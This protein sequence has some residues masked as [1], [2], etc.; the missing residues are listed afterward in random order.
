MLYRLLAWW[1]RRDL[2]RLRF[3]EQTAAGRALFEEVFGTVRDG[4]VLGF[5]GV[6]ESRMLACARRLPWHLRPFF[7][8][9]HAIGHAG[10]VACSIGR[11]S[12][13]A[14]FATSANQCIRFLSYGYWVA[15]SERYP[16]P[17]WPVEGG[18]WA[19]E[20]GHARY[21]RLMLNGLGFGRVLLAGGFDRATVD[22]LV[23]GHGEDDRR[24]ILHGVGR[25]LW[26]LHLGNPASL[27]RILAAH[28]DLA[29]PLAVGLGV[30]ICFTQ[31]TRLDAVRETL[32]AL[33]ADLAP[34]LWSGAGIAL[35][36]HSVNDPEAEAALEPGL[37]EDFRPWY[38]A[39][40]SASLEPRGERDDVDWYYRRLDV[41]PAGTRTR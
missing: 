36:F 29:E 7:H 12:P 3:P 34:A 2:D 40:R 8:E 9:G 28:G 11:R 30:A 21:R 25:V 27:S 15:I 26:F 16:L 23:L 24:A 22:R 13:E 20:P 14:S 17:S 39:A 6:A 18:F 38:L 32:A 35:R 31:A 33:P 41:E 19:E 4:G 1:F 37:A 5:Q 10:R